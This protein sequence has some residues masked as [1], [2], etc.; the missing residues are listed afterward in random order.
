MK[1]TFKP[2]IPWALFATLAVYFLFSAMYEDIIVPT[3]DFGGMGYDPRDE[4]FFELALLIFT[5]ILLP[6][7]VK[8]P[9]DLYNWLFFV[10]LLIPSA[11]LSTQQ[12]VDR[13]YLFLMFLSLWFL[14]FLRSVFSVVMPSFISLAPAREICG[15][16]ENYRKLPFYTV[17]IFVFLVLVFLAI[18]VHG[19]FNLNI[20]KVYEFRFNISQNMPLILRY[21]MPLAAVTLIG[22]LAAL[23]CHCRS[24]MGLFLVVFIGV[25]FFGFSSHKSMLFNPLI[26]IAVFYL[27]K[28]SRPH[29]IFLGGG[30]VLA[31]L[32]LLIPVDAF[33]V[34]GNL[35][36]NRI[37]FIPSHINFFYFDFF[38]YN[39]MMLWAQSKVSLGLVTSELPMDPMHYIGG[40]MTGDYNI[41]ANTGWV[42]NAYMNGRVLGIIVYATVIGCIFS[43]IDFWS[44][45][46][47]K[48]L[49]GAAFLV[50]VVT[51]TLTADLFI[52][53]MTTGLIALLLLFQIVTMWIQ[54]R[55][56]SNKNINVKDCYSNA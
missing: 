40:L 6:N 24:V 16:S 10:T 47:G 27:L 33:P 34:L 2:R 25:L 11:V 28:L 1:I 12:G 56:M 51:L 17:F 31:I 52:V 21:L 54:L 37:V 53:L 35:F 41:S 9:S 50:P 49:V 14:M 42:A 13:Y 39:S 3:F 4:I 32:T 44:C 15:L 20:N 7:R 43:L 8:A 36:A 38:S 45:I 46:Y 19:V 29:L 22:Y 26:T 30:G 48:Q 5:S 55:Q 23:S 18:N